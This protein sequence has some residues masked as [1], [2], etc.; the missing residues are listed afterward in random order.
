MSTPGSFNHLLWR[1]LK[2]VQPY[3]KLLFVSLT[4]ILSL[5]ILGP[6]RPWLI[7]KAVDL[8]II[9]TSNSTLLLYF[10][11]AIFGLLMVESV[12]IWLGAFYS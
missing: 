8:Y 10:L 4:S 7:G 5:A 1:L 3:R 11:G 9:E 12:F 2:E 6:L